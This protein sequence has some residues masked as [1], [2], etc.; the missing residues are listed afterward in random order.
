[1][2]KRLDHLLTRC[3][4]IMEMPDVDDPIT[5]MQGWMIHYLIRQEGR[6]VYQRELEQKLGVRRSTI[7]GILNLMEK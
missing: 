7:S 5:G 6:P 3:T 2:V 4:A 1:M